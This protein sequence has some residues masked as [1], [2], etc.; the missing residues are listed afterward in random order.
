MGIRKDILNWTGSFDPIYALISLI[1]GLL[2]NYINVR[3]IY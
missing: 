3:L 1:C 2:V